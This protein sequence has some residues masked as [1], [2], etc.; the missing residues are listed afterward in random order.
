MNESPNRL[1][2]AMRGAPAEPPRPTVP[3][4]FSTASFGSVD[5]SPV[6]ALRPCLF[7]AGGR[8]TLFGGS[9]HAQNPL[10]C[11]SLRA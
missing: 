5:N 9:K 3:G 7:C 8:L 10:G 6:V 1:G 11:S 2:W 4:R